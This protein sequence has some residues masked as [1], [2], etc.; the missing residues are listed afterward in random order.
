MIGK[1]A[2]VL[3]SL[4]SG[5]IYESYLPA[6]QASEVSKD[7]LVV[8]IGAS[9]CAPCRKM[10]AEIKANA[11]KYKGVNLAFVDYKS[12]WG[13]KLYSGSSVPALIKFKWDGDKW[14]RSDKRGYQSQLSLQR[15]VKQ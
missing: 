8:V 9:W 14:V 4:M 3:A 15:W 7:T 6:R 13:K 2:I 5:N 12:E 1:I 11:V 10:K